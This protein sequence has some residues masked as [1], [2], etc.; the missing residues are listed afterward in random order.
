MTIEE[1]MALADA[2]AEAARAAGY[3]DDID[4]RAE[5][6]VDK[7]RAALEEALSITSSFGG[8]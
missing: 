7:A 2:Y 3:S 5:Y 1:L 8:L 6:E 4:D